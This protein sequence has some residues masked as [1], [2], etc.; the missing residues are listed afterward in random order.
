MVW[1]KDEWGVEG[2]VKATLDKRYKLKQVQAPVTLMLYSKKY[3]VMRL[4]AIS[5]LFVLD[6]LNKTADSLQKQNKTK[7]NKTKKKHKYEF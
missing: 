4:D 3:A 5:H 2:V 6:F 1:K 7:T